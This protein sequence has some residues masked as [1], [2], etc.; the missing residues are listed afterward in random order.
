MPIPKLSAFTIFH[1]IVDD[2][3]TAWN[4]ISARKKVAGRGN[5]VFA[6]L[7]MV[8]LEFACRICKQDSTNTKLADFTKAINAIEPRYFTCLP[9]SC[10]AT[11]E[12]T[13]PGDNPDSH[14][15]GMMFDLIRSGK[16]TSIP[17]R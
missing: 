1:Y 4:A 7:S 14:L 11:K 10:C 13:L 9:G 8:L 16:A 17:R 6:L 5:Y 3:E 12:F 15:L 2:F